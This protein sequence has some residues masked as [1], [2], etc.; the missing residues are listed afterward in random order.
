MVGIVL[1]LL[2]V[3]IA[4]IIAPI[5]F[6]NKLS[7]RIDDLEGKINR[8]IEKQ[9]GSPE[10]SGESVDQE[11]PLQEESEY[12][13]RTPEAEAGKEKTEYQGTPEEPVEEAKEE[14]DV[15]NKIETK[16]ETQEEPEVATNTE[17]QAAQ[18]DYEAHNDNDYQSFDNDFMTRFREK[19]P[20]L[21]KFIGE[22]V[23]N[24]IGIAILVLGIGFFVQLAINEQ[25]IGEVG[26]VMIGIL[27]GGVLLAFAHRLR[28]RFTA[29]S[30]VLVGGGLA[31]LYFTITIAFQEY[32]LFSQPVAFGIMILITAFAV[33]LAVSYDRVELAVL[34]LL[35]GFASPF[36]VST[37][38]GNYITLFTYL[39]ILNA[40]MLTLSYLRNWYPVNIVAYLGT[41]ILYGTWLGNSFMAQANPPYWGAMV[42]ATLF[43]LVFFTMSII[44]NLKVRKRFNPIEFSILLTNT[45]LYFSV[46]MV[47]LDNLMDGRFQGLFTAWI[48]VFNFIFALAFYK[49]ADIDRNFRYLLIA[50][51]MTFLSLV[52]PIELDGNHITLFWAL[53]AVLLLWL[54]QR[55]GIYLM[56]AGALI[57]SG[58]MVISLV[59]D[60][61]DIYFIYEAELYP[62]LNKGF[63]TGIF[64]TGSLL[65]TFF[66]LTREH[67]VLFNRT[68]NIKPLIYGVAFVAIA[69]G[70]LTGSLELNHQM[71]AFKVKASLQ[72]LFNALYNYGF[73]TGLYLVLTQ[74]RN[75]VMIQLFTLLL[76][77]AVVLYPVTC[78]EAIIALRNEIFRGAMNFWNFLI[79]LPVWAFPFLFLYFLYRHVRMA[80][81][82]AVSFPS[83]A[84]RIYAWF[85]SAMVVLLLSLALNHWV[86]LSLKGSGYEIGA[87]LE[88]TI[89]I[90]YPILWGLCAFG[91]MGIGMR[92]NYKQL[93]LVSL[94][95][96]FFTLIKLFVYDIQEVSKAGKIAAFISLGI[97]LLIVSFMYQRLKRILL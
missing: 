4:F 58:L 40:G 70:F 88:N 23:I 22:N 55:S 28:E 7:S 93:R 37:G 14:P 42:F 62:L 48:A 17:T 46:G 10:K 83:N 92:F 79:H 34:A 84:P 24:K 3:V 63:M 5:L 56:K 33:L 19:F 32:Q 54:S 86:V 18:E 76:T 94:T 77:L 53:E 68:M 13:E 26:R 72:T 51:V 80:I 36:L 75:P 60:W 45:F 21:E 73:L 61:H 81:N 1:L 57:V 47:I 52:A 71:D 67:I 64:A 29:F 82:G 35:G 27:S 25:W 9:S 85:A 30:S 38:E 96:I 20:D 43:Y 78:S 41:I 31:V 66:L 16:A 74:K 12:S 90:G 91:L 97:L 2:L 11:P 87:I 50:L 8:L 39:L 6:F 69:T 89:K 15:E 65:A 44:Y 59:M 95:L 49:R